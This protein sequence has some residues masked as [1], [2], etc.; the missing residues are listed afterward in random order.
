[1][2]LPGSVRGLYGDFTQETYVAGTAEEDVVVV[3]VLHTRQHWSF[4]SIHPLRISHCTR[5]QTHV[6][7]L[8]VEVILESISNDHH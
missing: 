4:A 8:V 5:H 3:V 6:A 7:V 2:V 1:M